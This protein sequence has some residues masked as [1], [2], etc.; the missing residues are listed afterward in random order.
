MTTTDSA[1]HTCCFLG[2]REICETEALKVQLIQIIEHLIIEK[3]V[4]TF[5][6]GSKSR[7]NQLCYDMVT[8]LKENYPHIQRVYVRAE[9]PYIDESYRAYIMES[10]EDTYYPDKIKRAGKAVYMER[11]REMIDKS[12]YC[13]CYYDENYAPANSA[14]S[15]TGEAYMYAKKKGLHIS[16]I[17]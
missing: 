17:K 6:F 16:N 1:A 4:D 10:Y 2:H 5:L 13:I 7:F 8:K 9:Y 14:K 3:N 12:S 11:N 15:G